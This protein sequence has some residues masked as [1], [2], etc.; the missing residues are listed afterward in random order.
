MLAAMPTDEIPRLAGLKT[1]FI[2]R[3]D[4][5][6]KRTFEEQ[7]DLYDKILSEDA[8]DASNLFYSSTEGQE[9]ISKLPRL[10]EGLTK[11][12]ASLTGALLKDFLTELLELNPTDDEMLKIGMTKFSIDEIEDLDEDDEEEEEIKPRKPKVKPEDDGDDIEG[13]FKDYGLDE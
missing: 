11:I 8:I 9:I 13:F 12:T 4:E 2:E 1:K 5:L 3:Y 7:V 6:M 10:T